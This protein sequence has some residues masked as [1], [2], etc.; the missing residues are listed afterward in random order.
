MQ[1]P[2]FLAPSFTAAFSP[3]SDKAEAFAAFLRT[4][5][6]SKD[7]PAI[8]PALGIICAEQTA[9]EILILD[10]SADWSQPDAVRYRWSPSTAPEIPDAH[11]VWFGTP[12]ECKPIMDQRHALVADSNGGVALIDMIAQCAVFYAFVGGNPHSAEQL[13][14]GS[15]AVASS[16]GNRITLIPAF[17]TQQTEPLP[18]MFFST[19]LKNAHGVVW[20]DKR[21]ILWAIGLE[22]LVG[23]TYNFNTR[24]PQLQ[25]HITCDL[26]AFAQHG[27]DLIAVPDTDFLIS[28]GVGVSVFDRE[29]HVFVL[30]ADILN[31]KSISLTGSDK[32]CAIIAQK[33]TSHWW[34]DQ[35]CFLNSEFTPAGKRP[36]ARF[37][38]GRWWKLN[39]ANSRD[40]SALNRACNADIRKAPTS[41][42]TS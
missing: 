1:T 3:A 13:P 40:A 8:E 2:S 34:S 31:L 24:T 20:D 32:N 42:A 15:I 5:I 17:Y 33:P 27:H 37:Y 30:L 19:S 14:D 4:R 22:S 29:H 9:G 12:N 25:H 39:I 38:K 11:R 6:Q 23:Y 36:G 41:P 10:P 18:E 26:P 35:I 7:V 21:E 28:T 16:S